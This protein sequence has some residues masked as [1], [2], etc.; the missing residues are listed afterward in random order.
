ML[1]SK[2]RPSFRSDSHPRFAIITVVGV[3]DREVRKVWQV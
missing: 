1:R 3:S 2:L